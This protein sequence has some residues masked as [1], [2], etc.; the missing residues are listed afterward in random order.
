MDE[1]KVG[2]R[3]AGG[4][5]AGRP[6]GADRMRRA[7]AHL[8]AIGRSVAHEDAAVHARVESLDAPIHDLRRLGELGD[9]GDR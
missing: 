1:T 4:R 3:T 9:I 2:M 5:L 7:G 6:D 8:L